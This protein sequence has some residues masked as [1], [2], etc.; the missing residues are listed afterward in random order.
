[1]SKAIS[2][3]PASGGKLM[4]NLDTHILIYALQGNVTQ[5]E[6]H[7]LSSNSWSIAAI[8]FWELSKLVQLGRNQID[9]EAGDVA[10]L[11]SKRHS[12]PLYV[13]VSMQSTRL[14]FAADPADELIA[15][16]SIIH[17]IPLLTRD[18]RIL[19]SKMVPLA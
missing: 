11:L 4:V 9:L 1:I 7:V 13:A 17:Q 12:L 8:V 18:R 14:D 6:R 3:P 15:A 19:K 16:T 10:R 2:N 5:R